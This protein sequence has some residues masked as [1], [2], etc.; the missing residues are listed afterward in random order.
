MLLLLLLSSV[1][2]ADTI[3][4]PELQ[5]RPRFEAHTGR[6][7]DASGG[8][9][10]AISQRTRV[11]ASLSVGDVTGR[12]Q[13]QDV[14]LWGSETSTLADFSADG[15]DLHQAYLKWTPTEALTLTAG[16]QE[17]AFHEHRLVGTVGWAQQGRS[18]D[19]VRVATGTGKF[20]ADVVGVILN[21]ADP[22]AGTEDALVGMLRAGLAAD[23]K[24]QADILVIADRD[25]ATDRT[26]VTAGLYA[27]GTTAIV[28]GRVEGYYQLGSVG[29]ATIGAWLAGASVTIAPEVALNP[30]ITLWYDHLSGDP[31]PADDEIRAFDT[32]FATNHKFYGILDMMWFSIGGHRDGR[33]LQDAA[34]KLKADPV[35][36]LTVKLDGHAFLASAP[37]GGDS[38]L[39]TEVDLTGAYA[40]TEHL[41]AHLGGAVL[42]PS[43]GDPDIWGFVMLDVQL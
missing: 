37:Q 9:A 20:S 1:F 35:D 29:G 8:T 22:V 41:K 7:G 6:D 5:V 43:D 2:A 13:I 11:G 26:R 33:G 18:F 3:F 24:N 38:F 17:I 10:A 25:Q 16:R 40:I 32:L 21:E 15:L 34:L 42:V 30:S 36:G 14:R 39:G 12:A 28:S 4:E 31:D 19:G 27:K 23:K